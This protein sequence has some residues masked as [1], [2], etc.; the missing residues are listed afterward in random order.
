MLQYLLLEVTLDGLTAR[1]CKQSSGL[2]TTAFRLRPVQVISVPYACFEY[3]T[4]LFLLSS[5]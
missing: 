4:H 3:L 1:R 5:Y 2:E